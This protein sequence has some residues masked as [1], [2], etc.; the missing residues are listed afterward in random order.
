[1]LEHLPDEVPHVRLADAGVVDNLSWTV[2]HWVPGSMLSH[3]WADL[4]RTQRRTAAEQLGTWGEVSF[5]LV[6]FF[7]YE[8]HA[9]TGN[10]GFLVDDLDAAYARPRR[11]GER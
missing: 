10:I 4:D 7:E 2:T 9:G 8:P 11:R 1:M 6:Q 3:G 5:F